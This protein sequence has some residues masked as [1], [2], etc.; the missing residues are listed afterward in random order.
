[1]SVAHCLVFAF[2]QT[3][4]AG[5]ATA[6]VYLVILDVD[7]R[8]FAIACAKVAVDALIRV[9][10]RLQISISG[11]EAEYGTYRANGVAIGSS[12]SP[13]QYDED[14]QGN[15]CNDE[16][17]DALQPHGGIVERITVGTFSQVGQQIVSP[18]VEGSK[19]VVGNTSVCTVGSQ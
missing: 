15:G 16:S 12:A 17:R 5:H 11:Q 1:M 19:Q 4:H 13:C 9:D 10:N 18:L 14:D 3:I 6:V 8:S 7:T 2:V